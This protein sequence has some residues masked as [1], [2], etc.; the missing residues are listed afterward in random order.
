MGCHCSPLAPSHSDLAGLWLVP[1]GNIQVLACNQYLPEGLLSGSLR[2]TLQP[3]SCLA[4]GLVCR[5]WEP[6]PGSSPL[7]RAPRCSLGLLGA[8]VV[9]EFPPTLGFWR[10]QS[11]RVRWCFSLS[12]VFKA[13]TTSSPFIRVGHHTCLHPQLPSQHGSSQGSNPERPCLSS[14]RLHSSP[15]PDDQEVLSSASPA[16]VW[17]AAW[18]CH[19]PARTLLKAN[20]NPRAQLA[21][22]ANQ[23]KRG[24]GRALG[25]I[26]L[27][28]FIFKPGGTK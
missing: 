8:P 15:W 10:F 7:P 27:Y 23:Y 24:R 19:L 22:G 21:Q 13:F 6:S 11:L 4:A 1:L 17:W 25:P 5:R 12:L 14:H 2:E 16:L 3:P 28:W 9:L 26:G 20:S 18:Q